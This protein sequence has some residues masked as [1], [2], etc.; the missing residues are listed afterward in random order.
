MSAPHDTSV[1]RARRHAE[2][3]AEALGLTIED[4]AGIVVRRGNEVVVDRSACG[5]WQGVE[6]RLRGIARLAQR[7]SRAIPT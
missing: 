3:L 7:H 1:P 2:R 6:N 4:G 5:G